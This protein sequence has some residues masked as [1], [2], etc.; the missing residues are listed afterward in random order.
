MANNNT[1]HANTRSNNVKRTNVVKYRKPLNI[2]VGL[3]IFGVIFVYI[4]ICIVMYFRSDKIAGYEVREG[5]L[6]VSSSFDAL[7]VREEE[8]V[9]AD[10][11][12]YINFY[13][14]ECERVGANRLVYTIDEANKLMEYTQK[15]ENATISDEDM[16]YFK[17]LLVQYQ[18]NYNDERYNYV[19]H[20][21]SGIENNLFKLMNYTKTTDIEK[22]KLNESDGIHLGHAQ[23]SGI[24]SYCVD[25]YED[26]TLEGI[27]AEV[28]V[29]DTYEKGTIDNGSVVNAGEPAYKMCTDERWYLIVKLSNEQAALY[30]ALIREYETKKKEANPNALVD[31]YKITIEFVQTQTKSVAGLTL[32]HKADGT[33]GVLELND[34]MMQFA[35]ERYIPIIIETDEDRGLKIPLSSIVEKEFYMI[36]KDYLTK[37]G[38]NGKNGVN[39]LA[40]TEDGE[41]TSEFIEV[42]VYAEENEE[43]YIDQNALRIG[44]IILLNNAV[45]R[46]TITKSGTL[47]GVYN[48]NKGY[49]DFRQIIILYQNDEYAIVKS[50]TKYGLI[51]YDYIVLNA[52]TVND[53]DFIY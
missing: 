33:Y 28:F 16:Q 44:D 36:P 29:K 4:I 10:Y 39:R 53:D 50:N 13:N 8:I 15:T 51:M 49:A 7:A 42:T 27:N 6:A 23:K 18:N 37:G 41:M 45:D 12:G 35:S 25:G 14:R 48:M 17:K 11:S 31:T 26:L 1:K 47:E 9:Y 21:K 32:L 20:F 3:V 46:Y 43:Y 22:L 24:I 40:Y 34:S 2:N 30:D 5:S 38:K 52:D 19:Y